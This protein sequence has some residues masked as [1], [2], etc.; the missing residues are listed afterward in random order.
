MRGETEPEE[1]GLE[2]KETEPDPDGES[3]V[4]QLLVYLVLAHL[5]HIQQLPPSDEDPISP[6]SP[7][8]LGLYM[9]GGM[10]RIIQSGKPE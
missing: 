3:E 9:E 2:S 6:P 5:K 8:V 10:V 4:G 7:P 1:R